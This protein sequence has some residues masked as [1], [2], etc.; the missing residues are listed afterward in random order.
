MS[1]RRPTAL[2]RPHALYSAAAADLAALAADYVTVKTYYDGR[3]SILSSNPNPNPNP[4]LLTVTFNPRRAR[5][6]DIYNN[7]V[8]RSVG[9][10][11][12]VETIGRTADR[13]TEATDCFSFTANAV[14]NNTNKKPS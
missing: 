8:Q 13:Q 7:L 10:K 11:D 3:Q 2:P 4:R 9:S 14:G 6:I 1:D 5:V 12:R